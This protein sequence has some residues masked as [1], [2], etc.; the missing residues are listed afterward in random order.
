MYLILT[1]T[2]NLQKTVIFKNNVPLIGQQSLSDSLCHLQK[3]MSSQLKYLAYHSNY[4]ACLELYRPQYKDDA[5]FNFSHKYVVLMNWHLT[6]IIIYTYQI[7]MLHISNMYVKYFK[8][9]CIYLCILKW[10]LNLLKILP[11]KIW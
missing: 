5:S 2:L 4:P 3:K 8:L 10:V 7:C 9:M 6:N 11:K 1:Y